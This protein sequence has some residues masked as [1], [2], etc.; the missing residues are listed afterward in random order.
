LISEVSHALAQRD[1]G[2]LME[3]YESTTCS[4]IVKFW[5]EEP[6]AENGRVSWRGRITHIPSGQRRYF[7]E[8]DEI[9]DF[10]HP[11]LL[12]IGITLG[13]TSALN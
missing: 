12:A 5:L 9:R 7:D 13:D 1:D 8:Y 6:T 2:A 4:F 10:V 3:P 11:F